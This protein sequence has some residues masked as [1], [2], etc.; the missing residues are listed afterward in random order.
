MTERLINNLDPEDKAYFDELCRKA[1]SEGHSE[2]DAR[3]LS[4]MDVRQIQ[5][6]RF[7][8]TMG[9]SARVNQVDYDSLIPEVMDRLGPIFKRSTEEK[10]F[11]DLDDGSEAPDK[12]R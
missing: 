9:S 4:F 11:E 1:I 8:K 3:F 6:E 2:S 12:P 7:T 5:N 10:W